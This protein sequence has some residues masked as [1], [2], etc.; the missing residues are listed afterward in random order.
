MIKYGGR[1]LKQ[2]LHGL[3]TKV[4][5]EESLSEQWNEG[6]ICPIFK[7]GDRLIYKNYRPITLLNISYEIFAIFLNQRLTNIIENNL[8]DYKI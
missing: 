3:M 4:W 7:K 1:K 2:E 5:N 6:I 8:E